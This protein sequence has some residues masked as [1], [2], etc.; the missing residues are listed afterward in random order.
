MKVS[1]AHVLAAAILLASSD[2]GA[3]MPRLTVHHDNSFQGVSALF[4]VRA[5]VESYQDRVVDVTEPD[6]PQDVVVRL[7]DGQ[8]N[9]VGRHI[10]SKGVCGFA[11]YA[12]DYIRLSGDSPALVPVEPA[13]QAAR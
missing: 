10:G 6:L 8:G 2:A 13:G 7:F 4:A 1:G 9:E 12:F 3:A 5:C 11:R